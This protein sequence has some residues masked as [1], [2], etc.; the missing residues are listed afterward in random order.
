MGAKKRIIEKAKKYECGNIDY[1]LKSI[2]PNIIFS[3]SEN[4]SEP[5]LLDSRL[6][7]KPATPNN[8]KWPLQ[9]KSKNSHLAFFFQLN[10]EQ[11]K[12]FDIDNILPAHGILLCFGSVTNDIMWEQEIPDAFKIYYFLDTNALSLT[13]I[14]E[15]IPL[16]QKLKPRS[17]IPVVV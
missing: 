6:G 11:I 2:I 7:G 5:D 16:E 12:P 13:E 17:I 10:F 4:E 1:I 8:F 3:V 9:P 15:E 14:P